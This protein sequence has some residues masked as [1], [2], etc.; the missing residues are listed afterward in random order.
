M[1]STK[2]IDTKFKV[3]IFLIPGIWA[4]ISVATSIAWISA[5]TTQT[6]EHTTEQVNKI[7]LK[8]EDT[9]KAREDAK[10]EI[11]IIKNEIKNINEKVGKMDDKLDKIL[12][13]LP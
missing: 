11:G 5:Q 8:L 6:V 4:V 12:Q 10:V 2:D 7:E 3:I 9:I 1:T 13:R